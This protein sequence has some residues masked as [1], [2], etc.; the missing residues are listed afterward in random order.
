MADVLNAMGIA[1]AIL[2]GVLVLIVVITVATVKRGETAMHHM[3]KHG[4]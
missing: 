1:G 2:L 4:H 3:D